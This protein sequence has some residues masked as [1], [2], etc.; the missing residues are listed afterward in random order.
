MAKGSQKQQQPFCAIFLSDFV[1]FTVSN[2][3]QTKK[4]KPCCLPF[5]KA[6]DTASPAFS[7]DRRKLLQ[8]HP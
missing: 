2:I 8:P 5:G 1:E 7:R 4:N 3:Q 6:D